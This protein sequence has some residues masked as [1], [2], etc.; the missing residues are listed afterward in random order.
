MHCMFD[1]EFEVRTAT[2]N[3]VLYF[4]IAYV[5]RSVELVGLA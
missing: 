1:L 3:Y 2:Y 5:L 4:D